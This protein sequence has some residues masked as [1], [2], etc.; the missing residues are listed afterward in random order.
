MIG[1][2]PLEPGKHG[3]ITVRSNDSGRFVARVRVRDRDG[4][5]RQVTASGATKGAARRELEKRLSKRVPPSVTGLSGSMTV[6]E[7]GAFW[8]EHRH[9]SGT[10]SGRGVIKP[11]TLAAY[12]DAHHRIVTRALG[13]LRLQELTPGLLDGALQQLEEGGISTAQA[14]SVLNQMLGLAVRHGAVHVNP[15]IGVSSPARADR[16]VE[17]LTVEQARALRDLVAPSTLAK[18][19]GGRKPNAD[20]ADFVDVAL[21]TGA[22]I[23]EVLALQWRHLDLAAALPTVQISG[24]LVEPR[25]GYVQE[26]H[27]Q[28]ST[29]SKAVRTLILPDHVRTVLLQRRDGTDHAEE[30]DPVLSSGNGTWLWPNNLRTRLRAAVSEHDILVGTTPHTLRR[31]VGTLVAHEHSLDAAREQLGHSDPSVTFQHYVAARSVGPDLRDLLSR[32]FQ[33]QPIQ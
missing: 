25:R 24:T 9:R 3:E 17:A 11:Q 29:K 6:A 28:E 18:P 19:G 22:R 14:R 15:M 16:E 12:A 27:R 13:R 31:T 8:L 2:P 7:A 30:S 33:Q 1:R 32:F 21:G 20:L 23:G 10:A 5:V 4:T 26:L